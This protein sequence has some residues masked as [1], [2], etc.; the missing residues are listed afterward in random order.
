MATWK[1]IITDADDS[2]YKNSNVKSSDL[3]V[4]TASAVGG[5]KV[6]SNLS[7]VADGT[8]SASAGSNTTNSSMAFNTSTGVLTLTDS[9]SG[10]VTVDLDGRFPTDKI[11]NLGYTTGAT[12]GVVTSST[13]TDA[14]IPVQ[15]GNNAGLLDKTRNSAI[16]ANTAKVSNVSTNLSVS[17]TSSKV[18]INSSDGT[19]A[20]ISTANGTSAGMLSSTLFNA[21]NTNTNKTSNVTTNLSTSTTAGKVT[22]ASSDG[23]N[24][25]IGTATASSA[26]VLS[27]TL[28]NNIQTNNNKVSASGIVSCTETNVVN[29]LGA[30]DEN[31]TLHIGDTGADTTV[32]I[33]G[34]LTV[35]GT[36][37][38]VDSTNLKIGDNVI[39][40]NKDVTGTPTENAGFEVERGN[41]ANANF[42]WSES[43]DHFMLDYNSWKANVA[44]MQTANSS[45]PTSSDNEGGQTGAFWHRTGTNEVYVRTA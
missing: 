4:A 5:I 7:I 32:S 8:L 26:G 30:L 18:T 35:S 42:I 29:I 16:T 20:E 17:T 33:R 11:T 13:G 25:E 14:T 34:N 2:N 36:T 31:D 15:S 28:F 43:S 39:T 3:P 21:I 9:A 38:T 6:G 27:S 22:I 37:T 10:S 23:T 24:A 45:A 41:Q 44:T 40:L 12:N 19:N 1:R